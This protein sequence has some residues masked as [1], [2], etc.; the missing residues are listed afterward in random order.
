MGVVAKTSGGSSGSG[1]GVGGRG[2]LAVSQTDPKCCV[3]SAPTTNLSSSLAIDDL[4]DDDNASLPI[5]NRQGYWYAYNDGRSSQ[6]PAVTGGA[7]PPTAGGGHPCSLLPVP[8]A[9]A[10]KTGG[11][12]YSAA[13]AGSLAI[14]S[15]S[16]AS[17]VGLG[18]DFNNR[19]M[20]SCVYGASAY[21][22]ISFWA[23][24]SAAVRA[25]VAIPATTATST[26]GGTCVTNC[27]DHYGIL[28]PLTDTTTWKQFA[29]T[30]S[31]STTFAQSGW[32]TKVTFDPGALLGM[33]F[34]VAGS[35]TATTTAPYSFSIDDLAFIQ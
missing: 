18:F 13:T 25:M 23:K 16:E 7:L 32:G 31:D 22:G 9:C 30:F 28:V 3:A 26:S 4:E 17:F 33:Q 35:A 29:I 2:P 10:G 6:M 14:A 15:P 21:H 12:A 20:K 34:Q 27:S 19:L 11:T 24:G 8:P 1:A 5:G